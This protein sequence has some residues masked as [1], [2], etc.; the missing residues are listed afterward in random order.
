MSRQSSRSPV[1]WDATCG[2]QSKPTQPRTGVG[3]SREL[4][5]SSGTW[6][7]AGQRPPKC[8]RPVLSAGGSSSS[9]KPCYA[10]P[11]SRAPK[12]G[13]RVL[14]PTPSSLCRRDGLNFSPL[15][16]TGQRCLPR[17]EGRPHIGCTL[18]LP[19]TPP[20]CVLPVLQSPDGGPGPAGLITH[21]D[22][23]TS[24]QWG[25]NPVPLATPLRPGRVGMG[26]QT[27]RRHQRLPDPL[28]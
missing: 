11:G 16:D 2:G 28:L 22:R 4:V 8:V 6:S 26:H 5:C 18:F 9:C 24:P 14:C 27:A 3:G 15:A 1:T 10:P 19:P 13:K 25:Q 12:E 21:C 17:S 23:L 20:K 7:Q